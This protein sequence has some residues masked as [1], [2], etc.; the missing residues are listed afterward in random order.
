MPGFTQS[1]PHLTVPVGQLQT[2]I[3][4]VPPAPQEFP[5]A[6]QLAASVIVFVS[7]P[8]A[9]TPLQFAKPV[10]HMP[11]VHVPAMQM[12]VAC[13]NEHTVPQVPQ[14]FGSV[15]VS[16]HML[17]HKVVPIAHVQTPPTHVWSMLQA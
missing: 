7:Q 2:P 8:S 16:A 6:P 14:L 13:G 5:H 3:V 10:L 11:M 15:C 4:Q 12:A 9:T 17:P 1:F